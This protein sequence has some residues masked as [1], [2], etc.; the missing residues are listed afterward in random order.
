MTPERHTA[1]DLEAALD[2]GNRAVDVL[3]CVASARAADYVRDLL[4]RLQR[5]KPEPGVADLT[6][7]IRHEL[8][9]A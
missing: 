8:T 6:H 4:D 1:T 2:Q 5:W 3:A 9:T 7:R